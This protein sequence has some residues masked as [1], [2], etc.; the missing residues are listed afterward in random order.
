MSDT[1]DFESA[2]ADLGGDVSSPA[3]LATAS[4]WAEE[5]ARLTGLHAA[6]QANADAI[7]KRITELRTKTIPDAMDRAGLKE[8][9]LA[10][11]AKI[12]TTEFVSGSLPKEPEARDRALRSLVE[13]GGDSLIKTKVTVEFPRSGHNEALSLRGELADKGHDATM[14]SDVHPQTL[15]A[16]ARERIKNGEHIDPDALGL[17]VG[18]IAKLTPAKG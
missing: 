5:L 12:K 7:A 10:N 17:Y 1:N 18:R 15:A 6:A 11:G 2:L 13:C 14:F 9:T 3:D 8:I 16:F 4:A